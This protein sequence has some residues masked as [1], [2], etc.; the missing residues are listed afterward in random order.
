MQASL[1]EGI[2]EVRSSIENIERR[3]EEVVM[4][5]NG[6][7]RA[8][9]DAKQNAEMMIQEAEMKAKKITDQS[10][11]LISNALERQQIEYDKEV[12]QIKIRLYAELHHRISDMVIREIKKKVN[13]IKTDRNFQNAGIDVAIKNLERLINSSKKI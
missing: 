3:R 10:A 8:V 11:E 7:R 9:E 2:D 6:L 12:E 1:E 5:L 13:E 4:E